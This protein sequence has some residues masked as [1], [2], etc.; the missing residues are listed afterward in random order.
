MTLYDS[1]I[2]VLPA[3]TLAKSIIMLNT[4]VENKHKSY[5]II[6]ISSSKIL[7]C[8]GTMTSKKTEMVVKC[9]FS[10]SIIASNCTFYNQ[11]VCSIS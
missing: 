9:L 5:T 11:T 1:L 3:L 7:V 6:L 2:I 8:S 4:M 10:L